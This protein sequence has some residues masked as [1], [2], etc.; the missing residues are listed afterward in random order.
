M[1]FWPAIV[2]AALLALPLASLAQDPQPPGVTVPRL[3]GI[4]DPIPGAWAEYDI[5]EKGKPSTMRMAIVGKE[6]DAH[7][8]EVTNREGDSVNI[9]KMLVKGT[10]NDS[11]NIQ[12]LILKSGSGE[13]TEMPRDF[14][15]MG[16][17]M[18]TSMFSQR[19]GMP[20]NGAASVRVEDVGEKTVIVPG[21]TYTGMEKRIVDETGKTLSSFVY[22]QGVPPFGIVT[23][24]SADSTMRLKAHGSDAKTAITGEP[25]ILNMPRGMPEGMPRG[26]PPGSDHMMEPKK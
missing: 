5:V 10:P 17:K 8:Y 7:W 3:F 19:S 4:Y 25:R 12:R 20:A 14:V 11:E 22:V 13:P 15:V 21:G 26:M 16:R 24:D 2:S 1:R 18:A 6:G 9:I 23:S